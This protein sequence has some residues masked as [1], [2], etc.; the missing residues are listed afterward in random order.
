MCD[1]FDF[2]D[3]VIYPELVK[4]Q[5]KSVQVIHL[6]GDLG[7]KQGTFE[8]QTKEGVQF[9]GCGNLSSNE[10]NLIFENVNVNDSVLVF[11]HTP[12]LNKLV[13]KFVNV[14]NQ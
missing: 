10:Y 9:L 13:W 14:G 5:K 2:Y 4:V 1:T 12:S 7:Q 6:A 3:N 11:E 8:Y